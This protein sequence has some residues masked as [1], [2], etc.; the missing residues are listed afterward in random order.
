MNLCLISTFL[1]PAV[2]LMD[3]FKS[4][5]A[6]SSRY[7]LWF[8]G[9]KE[10]KKEK[11]E[12]GRKTETDQRDRDSQIEREGRRQ[13]GEKEGNYKLSEGY[14]ADFEDLAKELSTEREN[15]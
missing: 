12:R 9:R 8:K 3:G 13:G 4:L 10:G 2:K 6:S 1:F 15:K 11:R 5:R 14:Y 7:F